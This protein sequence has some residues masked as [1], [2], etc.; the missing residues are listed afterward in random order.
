MVRG[1][2]EDQY[3]RLLQ[4]QLAEKQPR[5]FASRENVG[6]LGSLVF[7]EQHLSEQSPNLLVGS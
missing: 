7:R 5:G 1:L 6:G 3:I 4:H 2:I